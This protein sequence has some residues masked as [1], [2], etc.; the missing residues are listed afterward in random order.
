MEHE[1]TLPWL[2]GQGSTRFG[3]KSSKWRLRDQFSCFLQ[4]HC[5]IFTAIEGRLENPGLHDPMGLRSECK[6]AVDTGM[7]KMYKNISRR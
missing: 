2:A 3:E 1:L 7:I 5:C 6:K 4:H